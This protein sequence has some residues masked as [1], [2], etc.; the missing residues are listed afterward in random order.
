[1]QMILNELSADFPLQG[2]EEG[3]RVMGL[4]LQTYV[5]MKK[6]LKSDRILLDRDYNGIFVAENYNI[7]KWRN[8]PDVDCEEK[9]MFLSLLNRSATYDSA[10][11]DEE[12]LKLLEMETLINGKSSLG[13]LYG[14][15]LNG[16]MIS[17]DTADIW[18]KPNLLL[19]LRKLKGNEISE[20]EV[21]LPN[22]SNR[23]TFESFKI[24]FSGV[25]KQDLLD[26]FLIGK[27]I[28]QKRTQ[29][30]PNLV[31][32]DNALRQLRSMNN[33]VIVRQVCI[34]LMELQEY[35]SEQHSSFDKDELK[36]ATLESKSTLKYYEAEHTFRLPDG[37]YKIFS[38]HIRFTG[39]E[40]RIFFLPDVKNK[41]CYIGHI[42][43]K[44]PNVTYH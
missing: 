5:M 30:F 10:V 31:F 12:S 26:K 33:P 34:R 14:Y 25:I 1:M 11:D 44:L 4:F 15:L 19:T 20:Q 18:R 43:S 37:R 3:K 28:L 16:C 41:I 7:L 39:I 27:D 9:R 40:G 22:V 29:I 23:E 6:L 38:W 17:F 36:N 24:K 21:I 32:C 42:G 2:K 13:C 8:D 35:F